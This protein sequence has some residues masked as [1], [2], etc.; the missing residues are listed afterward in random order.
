MGSSFRRKGK[1]REGKK[2]TARK[3]KNQK[4]RHEHFLKVTLRQTGE[5]VWEWENQNTRMCNQESTRSKDELKSRDQKGDRV[6]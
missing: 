6:T 4:G 5:R 2:I 1:Q 3:G